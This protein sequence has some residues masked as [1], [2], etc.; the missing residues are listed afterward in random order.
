MRSARSAQAVGGAGLVVA[1][2][3]TFLPWLRSGNA[4]RNSYTSFGVLRR[5]IGFHGVTEVLIR[6][7]PLLGAVSA[8]IV[9]LAVAGLHRTAGGVASATAAWAI[10]VASSALAHDP[11]AG[12]RVDP[13]GPTMTLTGATAVAAAAILTLIAQVR[14]GLGGTERERASGPAA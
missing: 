4:H 11:V 3:G 13:L 5:L 2:I 6:G 10:A 7:W 1:V 9:V 14:G 8:A 12:I